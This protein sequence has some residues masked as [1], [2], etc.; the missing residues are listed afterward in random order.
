MELR[1]T[2]AEKSFRYYFLFLEPIRISNIRGSFEDSKVT[3]NPAERDGSLF[4]VL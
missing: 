1:R 4:L 3:K 2:D